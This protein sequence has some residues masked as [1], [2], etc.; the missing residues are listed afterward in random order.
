[1]KALIGIKEVNLEKENKIQNAKE[2]LRPRELAALLGV[3]VWTVYT[4]SDRGKLPVVYRDNNRHGKQRI[5]R[6]KDIEEWL[7]KRRRETWE[8]TGYKN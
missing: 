8:Q 2:F 6:K 4:M 5:F 1:M 7:E 3:S